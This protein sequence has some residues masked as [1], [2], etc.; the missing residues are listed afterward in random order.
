MG[1]MRKI[2]FIFLVSILIFTPTIFA[3]N[4]GYDTG[5]DGGVQNVNININ[6]G[7]SFND[8]NASTACTGTE[9]LGGDGNCYSAVTGGD[10]NET[11]RFNALTGTDC[12]GTDKMVGVDNNGNAVCATDQTGGGGTTYTHL[13]NFTND[14]GFYNSTTIN[15]SELENQGD[16]KLGILDLFINTLIDNKITQSFIQAVGF[17]TKTE[18]DTN[19]TNANTSIK[20][21]AD[22]KF[23]NNINNFTGTLTDTKFCT[24]DS[25]TNKIVCTSNGGTSTTYYGG[26]GI[27]INASNNISITLGYQIPQ[28]CNNGEIAEYNTTSGGW[29]C[30]VDNTAASGMASW[31]LAS[32]D[33]AGSESITDGETV[34]IADD[35]SYLNITRVTNTITISLYENKLN[36]TIDSRDSDTTYSAGNGIILTSTTFSINTTYLNDNFVGQ[37]EYPNLDTDVTDDFDGVWGSLTGVPSGFSDNIDNDSGNTLTHL[38][39]FTDNLGNRGYTSLSNF[40]D[41]LNHIEDNQSWNESYADTKYSIGAHTIDTNVLTDVTYNT[42][43]FD[44]VGSQLNIVLSWLSSYLN[45]WLTGKTTDDLTQGSN[46]LYDNKSWNES[47]ADTK[48]STGAH[49]TDT[50]ETIRFNNLANTDCSGTDKMVG[51]DANGNVVCTTDI[52]TDSNLTETDVEAFIFDNDNNANFNMSSNNITFIGGE[53]YSNSTCIKINGATAIFEVC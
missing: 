19:I 35:N 10:T 16:G 1:I 9:Y 45:N 17:Y 31:V 12:S 24:Y 50:N 28:G 53:I 49:T 34:T 22:N 7:T 13:S 18:V 20:N 39:N 8:T 43:E 30:G 25:G 48:Y 42:T 21:Y 15:T 33:T 52:D 40:T 23:F 36:S 27:E 37:N 2:L 26:D 5:T 32:S 3:L 29:D 14:Q 46:N 51:T 41:D 44:G 47:Y 6:T 4:V 11:T 38:S